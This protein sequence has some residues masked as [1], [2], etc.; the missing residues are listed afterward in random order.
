[1][2]T[3]IA[4]QRMIT[5]HRALFFSSVLVLIR[6]SHH[7]GRDM[8]MRYCLFPPRTAALRGVRDGLDNASRGGFV[9][10]CSSNSPFWP[11]A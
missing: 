2:P 8:T 10:M 7:V 4:M 6:S 9:E 11:P 3:A 5:A 1:M